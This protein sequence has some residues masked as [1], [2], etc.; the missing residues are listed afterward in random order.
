MEEL[1]HID[2]AWKQKVRRNVLRWYESHGRDLPWRGADP[3]HIWVSEIMLQQT[4]VAAVKPYFDRFMR[5]FPNVQSL[6]N[7]PEEDVLKLWEGLGY[8]SRARNLAKAARFVVDEYAGEF[9]RDVDALQKLPGVGKY[10]AGA[11]ASFA[12]DLRA[13]IVEANTLRLYARLIGYAENARSTAGQRVLWR[14]AED[15]LPGRSSA[16]G[17]GA[18]RLNQALMDLGAT[19]CTPVDPACHACPAQRQC[20]AFADNSQSEIPQLPKRAQMTPMLHAAVVVEHAGKVLVR[21]YADNERWAGLWDF[22]RVELGRDNNESPDDAAVVVRVG[23]MVRELT[24]VKVQVESCMRTI[25]HT[26][27]RYKIRLIVFRGVA[28]DPDS[29]N[30]DMLKWVDMAE[31]SKLPL[32]MTGRKIADLLAR[33]SPTRRLVAVHE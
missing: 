2:S 6:A 10:T 29:A 23:E 12:F 1:E 27:T 33:P 9:P 5:R 16:N 7:A 26:V 18:G 13:P 17:S 15:I 20:R 8:Y 32:S 4:T 19:V 30:R 22:A 14:F 21:Q 11:I 28:V 31:L 25:R 24:G 3:Y